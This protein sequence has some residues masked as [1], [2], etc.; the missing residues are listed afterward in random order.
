MVRSV[1]AFVLTLAVSGLVAA[2]N[3]GVVRKLKWTDL[4][5]PGELVPPQVVDHTRVPTFD[6]FPYTAAVETVLEL[7][8]QLVKLP[9]FVVPLAVV[10]DKVASFL[11]VPYC[12]A[13]IHQPPPS[14]NQIVFVVF[15]G[16]VE[17][18]SMYDRVWVTGTLGL[19]VHSSS[20]AHAGYSM[21]GRV[22][23]KCRY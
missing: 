2:D 18:E 8:G 3:A 13:C 19:D 12:G 21:L 23:E 5:P 22:V 14:P 15:A 10:G 20:V 9:G 7:D 11:L 4:L 16:P 6:D 17:L 1:L